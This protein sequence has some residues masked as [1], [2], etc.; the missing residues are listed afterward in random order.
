MVQFSVEFKTFFVSVYSLPLIK[1]YMYTKI[2]QLVSVRE[3]NLQ[4]T[5]ENIFFN[6]PIMTQVNCKS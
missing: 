1:V 2:I 4:V 3:T 5:P 6:V